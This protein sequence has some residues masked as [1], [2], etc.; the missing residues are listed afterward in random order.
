MKN[1]SSLF[2]AIRRSGADADP[3]L[4]TGRTRLL[5]TAAMLACAFAVI[6]L[7]LIDVTLLKEGNEPT[8]AERRS[9]TVLPISRADI[10]DRNGVLLATSLKTA[11]LYADPHQVLDPK[12][13]AARL[14]QVLPGLSEA[15]VYQRLTEDK[16][17]VWLYRHLTPHQQYVVNRLGIPG[18]NFL[19]EERRVYPA[20]ALAAHL[21]GFTDIDNRGLAGVER[22]FDKRLHD[23]AKPLRLSLD[24]RIQHAMRVELSRAMHV[25]RAVGA[26]GLVQDVRTGEVLA[27]VSLPDFDPNLPTTIDPETRFNRATLGVYEMGSTFKIFT[28]AMALDSGKVTLQSGYDA[29]N[30]IHVARYTIHDDHPKHRWLSIPEII[31]YS[32]NIGAAKM[33]LDVGID[34]QRAFLGKIGMLRPAKIELP[35]VADPLVP[36]P[37]REINTMTIA[38]GHGIAVSPMQLV[39]GMSAMVNGGV[40][41]TATVLKCDDPAAVP[42]KRVISPRTS[43]EV[44]RLMR[45]VVE[46]G[47][48]KYAEARG[49]LVGG[50]TGTAEKVFGKRYKAKALMSSFIGAFPINAPRYIVYA[51]LDEPSGTKKT[52]GY[53]TGGWVAAPVVRNVVLRMASILGIRPVDEDSPEIRQQLAIDIV[54]KDTGKRRLASF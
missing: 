3:A 40:L 1:R 39:D 16:R 13:A 14:V 43:D 35:E 32:S 5:F 36:N 10:V 29:T 53:A 11:S 28:A 46:D 24:V 19:T 33:A 45:L 22:E 38:F 44:R 42:G 12:D 54:S 25:F 41:H 20:G 23:S 48:G 9:P 47:T 6:G 4:D 49:F 50:K 18:L 31:M 37:W 34:G 26:A 8:V 27:M 51:M 52:F 15:E 7:R 2:A 21:L 17:F 30:P